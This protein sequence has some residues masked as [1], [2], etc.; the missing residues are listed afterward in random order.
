MSLLSEVLHVVSDFLSPK[1]LLV[2]ICSSAE[3]K[4]TLSDDVALWGSVLRRAAQR[5]VLNGLLHRKQVCLPSI[6]LPCIRGQV[7]TCVRCWKLNAPRGMRHGAV[8]SVCNSCADG[9][10]AQ[11]ELWDRVRIG[12]EIRASETPIK[13]SR[14]MTWFRTGRL[15]YARRRSGGATLYWAS[16]VRALM[17]SK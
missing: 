7:S 2:L 3:F 5:R 10:D 17:Y 1:D 11:L 15:V 4:T 13:V 16:D 6:I 8:I 9:R 12:N 14:V